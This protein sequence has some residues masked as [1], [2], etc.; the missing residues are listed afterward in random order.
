MTQNIIRFLVVFA[1]IAAAITFAV[2]GLWWG[3]LIAILALAVYFYVTVKQNR[4]FLAWMH[5]G[6]QNFDKAEAILEKIPDPEALAAKQQG[7]FY[8]T[9]GVINLT[10]QRLD[11]AEKFFKK[12]LSTELTENDQSMVY[13]Q[14]CGIEMGR[15]N[16]KKATDYLNKAKKLKHHKN[17]DPEIAKL[18]SMMKQVGKQQRQQQLGG[19]R[20]GRPF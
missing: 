20:G 16:K 19:R 18:E 11:P 12:A 6:R 15:G 5:V 3:V 4:V 13:M 14:L 9:R 7:Y 17:L 2:K 8:M 1:A 10:K